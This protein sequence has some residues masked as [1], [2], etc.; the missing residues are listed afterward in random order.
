MEVPAKTQIIATGP[1]LLGGRARQL[2]GTASTVFSQE[3]QCCFHA[4]RVRVLPVN[5]DSCC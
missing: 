5:Q 3:P 4:L 1:F 2:T